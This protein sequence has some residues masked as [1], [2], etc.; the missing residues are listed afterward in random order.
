MSDEALLAGLRD[1]GDDAAIHAVYRKYR[2]PCLRFLVG[3]IIPPEAPNRQDLAVELFTEALIILVENVRSGRLTE[4]TARLDTYL[5]AVARNRYRKL[6]RRNREPNWDPDRLPEALVEP[7][8]GSEAEE[9]RQEVHRKMRE[10]GPRCR[11]LLAH[12]YFLQLDWATIAEVLGYKNAASAKT[13]KA[14]CMARLRV[15][16]GVSP[17]T[18]SNDPN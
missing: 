15:S 17:P 12:F 7:P 8:N 4:L 1:S 18:K 13:N 16:Y 2:D 9:V 14:K 3:R 10:L 6:Q 5:N 11:Q